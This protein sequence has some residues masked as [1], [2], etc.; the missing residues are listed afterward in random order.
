VYRGT[1]TVFRWIANGIHGDGESFLGLFTMKSLAQ[2]ASIMRVDWDRRVRHDYRFWVT[3]EIS[4]QAV[5]WDEGRR[6]LEAL[7]S[8]L[9]PNKGHTALEIGCG[10]G[11]MLRPAL[12]RFRKVIGVDVSPQAIQKANELIPQESRVQL[13]A[14]SGFDLAEIAD[15]SIDVVWSFASLPHMPTRVFAAY[16]LEIRRVLRPGGSARLQVFIGHNLNPAES[17]SLRLR[18]YQEKPLYEA[19]AQAGFRADALT[20]VELPLGELLDELCL[21]SVVLSLSPESV[22]SVDA[23]TIAATLLPNGPESDD[24]RV[25]CSEFEAWLALHYADRL[26]QDGEFDKAR[27]AL[28]Y[29]TQHCKSARIDIQDTLEKVSRA[30]AQQEVK[31]HIGSPSQQDEYL[32]ANME[33]LQARFPKVY[34]AVVG[35]VPRDGKNTTEIRPTAYGPVLWVNQTCLDHAEKPTV[36]GD[37][38]IKRALNDP[39]I[40]QASHLVI[41]GMGCGYHIESVLQ[42]GSHSVSCIE[43]NTNAFRQ[44][45]TVRDMRPILS[46]LV[47]LQV[48][49]AGGADSIGVDAELLMRPQMIP[50]YGTSIEKITNAFYSRRGLSSLHPKIAVLGPL[51]GGTLPI[52]HY[53]THALASLEQRVR[54]LDMSGFNSGYELIGSFLHS[55][56]REKMARQGYVEMLSSLLLESCADKPF[57][58]LICMAQAPISPRALTELRRQGV[59]TVLWFVE[60]YLRFT[61]WQEMAKYFD[62][63]FTIQRGE[64]IEAI[65]KAGAGQVHYLPT[66]C[67]PRIHAPVSLTAEERERWGSPISFVGAGYYNRRQTFAGL[68]HL[69]FK[70]WGTEWPVCKPFDKMLQEAGRR[71]TPEEYIKIF[72]ST[73]ININL[74]SSN[75]RDGVDPSGDFIN[76]R[77]FELASCGAFQLVDERALLPEA[78]E[79]GEEIITFSSLPDLKDKI[80]YYLERPDERE[81]IGRKSRERVLREH[82]YEKRLQ[83]MLSVIYSSSYQRLRAR[84]QASPWTEMIRRAEFDPELQERCE[85]AFA[86]G[87]EPILDG[88]I[89]DITTGQGQLTDAEKKLL[90]LFHVRK[91]II[92]MEHEGAGVKN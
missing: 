63:V 39:R 23:D 79:V 52:G 60:D 47:S 43:P 37:A 89:A 30:A 72:N 4:Q 61:Y 44:A 41:V 56:F 68:A 67:D 54:L 10:V 58:V 5:M 33:V 80:A 14:N 19:V 15:S 38:W 53:T 28:E 69:P 24:D 46:K 36:A 76:P 29:V 2:L 81:R 1:G 86:R 18:A 82:T 35:H 51:Q 6:D 49:D 21:K 78:F 85:R 48:G 42:K 25:S 11:R 31:A 13:L 62:Y 66:A 92:R 7:L 32:A 64:C 59:I 45:L 75:E 20:P 9:D 22:G 16:L 55:D 77:T 87:E 50:L 27:S 8:G 88:L 40:T 90:F 26:Y 91:Q 17:D 65:R 83:E 71:L 3:N 74:H 57:D 70:I 73:D 34:D 84:E 12:E